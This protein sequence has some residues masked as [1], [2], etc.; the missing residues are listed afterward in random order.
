MSTLPVPTVEI[1]SGIR[2]LQG[3]VST[4]PMALP[5]RAL[6]RFQWLRVNSL[7]RFW[8][9][10]T[11]GYGTLESRQAKLFAGFSAAAYRWAYLVQGHPRGLSVYY[12]LP[13]SVD[14]IRSWRPSFSAA[15]PGCDISP[16]PLPE[17]IAK[18]L[19]CLPHG[20]ALTGNPVSPPLRSH[21]SV[22]QATLESVFQAM[23][24]GHW[25]YLVL[26]EPI[27]SERIQRTLDDL[28]AEE[29]ELVSAYLRR[30]SAEE[31][32]NPRAQYYLD[33][34]RAAR[35]KYEIGERH[36]MWTVRVVL[37]TDDTQL[38]D[39]GGQALLGAFAGPDNRPQPIR[40][41]PLSPNG[42][43]GLVPSTCLT[44]PEAV[45]LARLPADEFSGYR[46]RDFVRFAVAPP[47]VKQKQR[48][49]VGTVQDGG[50]SANWFEVAVDDLC[51]HAL[52]AGVPGSG[53]TATCQY[54]L[55]QLWEEHRIPWL[56]LEPSMKSEY[57][58]LLAAPVGEELRVF[59]LADETGVPLHFNPLEIQPGVHVQQHID[60]LVALFGAA[61]A[62]P[63]PMPYVLGHALH[64]VYEER[65]WNLVSGIHPRGP[66]LA[67]QP[68]LSDLADTTAQLVS[69]LGYDREITGNIQAGL[70]TRLRSLTI[71]GRGRMLDCPHSYPMADLLRWPSVLEF[72]AM[73]SDEDKSFVLGALLLRLVEYRQNAGMST[74]TRHLTLVE[75]AHRLLAA[76]APNQSSEEA[77]ARGKAVETFC[78]LLAEVRAFGESIVIVDQ[79][80]T[81]LAPDILK[82]TNLKLVHRLVSEDE[83]R[84]VGG[85]MNLSEQQTSYLSTLP[86]GTAVVYMEG[87]EKPSLIRIPN[88]SRRYSERAYPEKRDLIE[89][90]RE[91]LPRPDSTAGPSCARGVGGSGSSLP[92]CP[93]CEAGHC[94]ARHAIV[95]HLL[96][97]DH[98]A[99]FA[100]ALDAG[101]PGLWLF[102]TRVARQVTGALR[103]KTPYCVVMNI[104]AL[105]GYDVSTSDKI[106]RNLSRYLEHAE[107]EPK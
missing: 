41:S 89:H 57:R 6:R 78:N 21:K 3:D 66:D 14:A 5:A 30:G 64:R 79:V 94:Q 42:A 87:S 103:P 7:C 31:N 96:R 55:R 17:T 67:P 29:R 72:S 22:P 28:S 106:R 75:E 58:G 34:L 43:G 77:N 35:K 11:L 71:G 99:G 68:A 37:L 16:G 69:E 4:E 10:D 76:A 12:A 83:R 93:G 33:L 19:V 54:L 56:V 15:F 97:V 84:R 23:M 95:N 27:S 24:G 91:R 74:N 32:N 39:L 61:F 81:K 50:R 102:G 47:F 45:S 63:T 107:R 60:G 25:A 101:W 26:G 85:C 46:V 73:G 70:L 90:M 40:L 92:S 38:L 65:D 8:A 51:K 18:G 86:C 53:K 1:S 62:L 80:P 100:E 36:G 82:N 48:I 104:A 49:A 13:G 20:A 98:S 59:T 52:V 2:R 44:T 9:H 88:H 105:A